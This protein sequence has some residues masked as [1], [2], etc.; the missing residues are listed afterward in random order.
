MIQKNKNSSTQKEVKELKARLKNLKQKSKDG[1]GDNN[2]YLI[3][4]SIF[5]AGFFIAGALLFSGG[6]GNSGSSGA[7]GTA[8]QAPP[9][10]SLPTANSGNSDNVQPLTAQD[11][12]RGNLDAPVKIVEFSDTECPFCKRFHSTM[13]QVVEEYSDEVVWVYRHFPLDSL[14]LKARREAAATEL[15]A[16]LGGNDAFWAYTDR[17]FEIT[18]SNDGLELSQLV[19][20]AKDVGLPQKPFQDLVDGN[21]IQGGKFAQHIEENYQDSIA[22]GGRGTPY[23]VI[24]APN[25]DTFPIS[26]AQPY[27]SFKA[28]IDLALKSK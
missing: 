9:A 16:E 8:Q 24:I 26:G 27:S 10:P 1:K 28:T 7:V 18:P 6:G 21:D 20:I 3:P 11:H 14:H 2:P 5:I 13:Q 12:I 19:Q 25:G 22:S 23:T 4:I 17:L 15:A